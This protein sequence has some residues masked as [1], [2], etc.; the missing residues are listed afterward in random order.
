MQAYEQHPDL[1]TAAYSALA[2]DAVA[3]CLGILIL[4][5]RTA[6]WNGTWAFWGGA[7]AVIGLFNR[8]FSAGV[9]VQLHLL[10]ELPA[11]GRVGPGL[12]GNLR[13]RRLFALA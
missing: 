11:L 9:G 4:V 7:C 1:V 5:H 13:K 12:R 3:L 6:A 2:F 10:G 8:T